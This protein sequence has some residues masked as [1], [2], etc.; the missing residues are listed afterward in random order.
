MH[1]FSFT[2][3]DEFYNILNIR[4]HEQSDQ[5]WHSDSH[6]YVLVAE[7]DGV[8]DR[9]QRSV[10]KVLLV[11]TGDVEHMGVICS[12]VSQQG[13]RCVFL[14]RGIKEGSSHTPKHS[15]WLSLGRPISFV[16]KPVYFSENN[17]LNTT[18]NKF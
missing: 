11:T 2:K 3:R 5:C 14:F 15:G 7:E 1:K 6:T 17:I 18:L 9:L 8:F 12:G 13:A 10:V 4:K 16:P